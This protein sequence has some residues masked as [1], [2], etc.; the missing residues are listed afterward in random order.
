MTLAAPE[1]RR[2]RTGGKPV[3]LTIEG[4]RSEAQQEFY[5]RTAQH[6][7]A[8]LDD[9]KNSRYVDFPRMVG[10]ESMA[11]CNASCG[12]C[13]YPTMER[14]G[15][16]MSDELIARLVDELDYEFPKDLPISVCL[17]RLNEP[18]LDKRTFP[19]VEALNTRVPQAGI[20]MY[21]NASPLTEANAQRLTEWRNVEL[22][23][24]SFNDHRESAYEATM[25]IP[26]R[27]TVESVDRLHALREAGDLNFEITIS[28]VGDATS[29]DDDFKE[30]VGR[31]WPVF[32]T[33]VWEEYEFVSS[34]AAFNPALVPDVGCHQWY[35]LS[36]LASGKVI[37]CCADALGS[38]PIADV[39]DESMLAIYNH[40]DRRALRADLPSR[41]F[42]DP[43]FACVRH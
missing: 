8:G 26:F 5:E 25:G 2:R 24:I 12:F 19:L 21:T 29:A 3:F 37:F 27:K 20:W 34:D 16:R 28:R 40:P 10:I 33:L 6:Y 7:E 42:V 17:S 9:L 39:N 41:K 35:H 30:W 38:A 32:Q 18:F 15:D 4:R 43:C 23:N 14:K 13:P 36:I 11:V 22:F 31:R 1:T